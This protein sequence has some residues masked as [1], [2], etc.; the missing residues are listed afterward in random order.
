MEDSLQALLL[1]G[2]IKASYLHIQVVK[3]I[4]S[5]S[6]I[7]ADKTRAA[8]LEVSKAHVAKPLIE[9]TSYKVIKCIKEDNMTLNTNPRF[10]PVQHKSKLEIENLDGKVKE[11]ED[12]LRKRSKA[13]MYTDIESLEPKLVHSKIPEITLKV[14]TKSRVITTNKGNYQICTVKDWKGKKTSVNLYSKLIDNVQVF[15]IYKFTNLRKGEILKNDELQMRLHTTNFTKLTEGT[16]DDTLN[17]KHVINGDQSVV[18]ELIGVGEVTSYKSCKFHLSKISD[19]DKCPKCDKKLA[20]EDIN[21]DFRIEVYIEEKLDENEESDVKQIM[22]FKKA[23]VEKY[24][25]DIDA[26]AQELLAKRIRIDYNVETGSR[27]IAVSIE[28]VE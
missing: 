2:Q 27:Y 6:Y 22:I 9:G 4:D 21:D 19:T 14:M 8:I 18:G 15:G 23:F 10:K 25:N 11:L 20:A 17:F 13:K 3:Q 12:F 24:Q 16:I 1:H 7:I 26:T 28:L 5:S